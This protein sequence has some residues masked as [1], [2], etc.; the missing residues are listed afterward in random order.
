VDEDIIEIDQLEP[1]H[2]VL[3]IPARRLIVIGRTLEEA[4]DWARAVVE[5]RGSEAAG[6][7]HS[8]YPLSEVSTLGDESPASAA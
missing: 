6:P 3:V 4:R 5:G 2:V 7:A 8:E 1:G